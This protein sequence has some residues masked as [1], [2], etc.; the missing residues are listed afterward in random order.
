MVGDYGPWLSTFLL[1]HYVFLPLSKRI[2]SFEP[3]LACRLQRLSIWSPLNFLSS[4]KELCLRG[5]I[6]TSFV[7]RDKLSFSSETTSFA[8]YIDMPVCSQ[9]YTKC[10]GAITTKSRVW[11]TL[12][13][14]KKFG[15]IVKI[16]ENAVNQHFLLFLQS[17]PAFHNTISNFY[18]LVHVLTLSQ[19]TNS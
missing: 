8:V 18:Y 17:H 6:A 9:Y 15:N 5:N 2:P 1:F 3:N 10:F 16:G 14:K 11:T 19:T 4:G 12:A 13:G 7:S